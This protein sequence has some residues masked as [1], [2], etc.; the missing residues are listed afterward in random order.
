VHEGPV[1][2]VAPAEL[3]RIRADY[4]T[5]YGQCVNCESCQVPLHP[6]RTRLLDI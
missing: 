1:P 5:G 2:D 6:L 4:L 3:R